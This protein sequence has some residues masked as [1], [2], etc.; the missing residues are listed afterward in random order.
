[1]C[2]DLLLIVD[3]ESFADTIKLQKHILLSEIKKKLG[4]RK[5]DVLI[6]SRDTMES[7]VFFLQWFILNLLFYTGIDLTALAPFC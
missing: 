4:D 5:T 2:C 3:H 1:M 6:V 7:D